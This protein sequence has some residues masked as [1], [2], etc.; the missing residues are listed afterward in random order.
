MTA[1]GAEERR[2]TGLWRCHRDEHEPALI[3]GSG[4]IPAH[5][6]PGHYFVRVKEE[7]CASSS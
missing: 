2:A 3:H 4:T 7:P 6:V 1:C 5:T